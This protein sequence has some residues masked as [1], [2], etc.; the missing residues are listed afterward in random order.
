MFLLNDINLLYLFNQL[1]FY[2]NIF[3]NTKL[4]WIGD[5]VVV[6]NLS[7]SFSDK[8]K[9]LAKVLII[10]LIIVEYNIIGI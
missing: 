4:L 3:N 5:W 8:D 1:T 6:L 10:V 9:Y 2:Y 7:I